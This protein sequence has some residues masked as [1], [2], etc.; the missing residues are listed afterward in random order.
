MALGCALLLGLVDV[1]EIKA[2]YGHRVAISAFGAYL[3]L[4]DELAE[5][6]TPRARAILALADA[7][8]AAL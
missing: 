8:V 1:A 6:Y 7:M 2:R 5:A 3:H 4:R